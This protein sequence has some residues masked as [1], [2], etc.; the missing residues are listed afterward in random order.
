M[1]NTE[2]IEFLLPI[3]IAILIFAIYVAT[4]NDYNKNPSKYGGIGYPIAMAIVF[5]ICF[6][7]AIYMVR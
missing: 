6:L 5:F 7:I 3:A 4:F 1:N 2:S